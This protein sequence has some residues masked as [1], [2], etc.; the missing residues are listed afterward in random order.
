MRRTM[1]N[2]TPHIMRLGSFFFHQVGVIQSIIAESHNRMKCLPG[3]EGCNKKQAAPIWSFV[4]PAFG[5]AANLSAAADE[6]GTRWRLV[7]ILHL[8]SRELKMANE[9]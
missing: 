1:K 2:Y 8:R 4:G 9:S 5:A 6:S 3:K 7:A